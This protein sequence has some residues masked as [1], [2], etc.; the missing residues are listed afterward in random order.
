MKQLIYLL[1]LLPLISSAQFGTTKYTIPPAN[2]VWQPELIV[3]NNEL[4][5]TADNDT[6]APTLWCFCNGAMNKLVDIT[7]GYGIKVSFGGQYRNGNLCVVNGEIYMIAS[8]D[9]NGFELYKYNGTRTLQLVSNLNG[10]GPSDPAGLTVLNNK[11]YFTATISSFSLFTRQLFVFDPST[12]STIQLTNFSVNNSD[13]PQLTAFG[14]NIA[15]TYRSQ[16]FLPQIL[17][18]CNTTNNSINYIDSISASLLT[19]VNGQLY[20]IGQKNTQLGQLYTYNINSGVTQ[21]TNIPD[22]ST[23]ASIVTRSNNNLHMGVMNNSIYFIYTYN[24]ITQFNKTGRLLEYNTVT[25]QLRGI[26]TFFNAYTINPDMLIYNNKLY[27]NYLTA[28]NK[29]AATWVYDGINQ[30]YQLP[31][32]FFPKPDLFDGYNFTGK[33]N[34]VFMSCRDGYSYTIYKFNEQSLSIGD[35]PDTAS[36]TT[37]PNPATTELNIDINLQQ[38]VSLAVTLTDIYGRVVY[39]RKA[40]EYHTGNNHTSINISA[41]PN[42]I[43]IYNITTTNGYRLKTGTTLKKD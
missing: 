12:G 29:D 28:P 22:T 24:N 7:N 17:Y 27:V 3:A 23:A 16:T 13:I 40:E 36:I 18:Y 37:Y 32:N 5:F 34:D 25:N 4:Y 20:Y 15:F 6:T 21:L 10:P 31:I 26:Q 33:D 1:L 9:S 38:P 39:T 42:G 11:I 19:D 30:S 2:S 35:I 14:N 41:L 43:Y 8:I